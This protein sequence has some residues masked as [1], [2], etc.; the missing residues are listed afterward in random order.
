M[1]QKSWL[2]MKMK[3]L[4]EMAKDPVSAI[5]SDTVQRGYL[6]ATKVS[7]GNLAERADVALV[8]V[9]QRSKEFLTIWGDTR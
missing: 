2:L 3:G 5:S 6:T 9:Q 7:D 4:F 8:G 1:L